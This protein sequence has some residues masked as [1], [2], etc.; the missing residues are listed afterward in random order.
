MIEAKT[1]DFWAIVDGR[2]E[3]PAS[4]KL[5][6]WRFVGFDEATGVL[7]C[8]FEATEAF[9]NPVGLV[10]GGILAAM[11]DEAMGPVAAAVSRGAVLAQ[12][13]EMKVSYMRA[14]RPGTIYGEGRI[15]QRGREIVFLEGKL[16]D[17]ERRTIATAT[18]TARAHGA[19]A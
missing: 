15:V 3:P 1:T 4:A 11:L 17:A 18:A 10:Q 2:V 8:A 9:L 16:F 6:G 19:A 12:T 14:A 5:V 13:L 7:S